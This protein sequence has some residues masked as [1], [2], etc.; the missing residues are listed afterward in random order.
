MCAG[1]A[2]GEQFGG[3]PD[4]GSAAAIVE[5]AENGDCWDGDPATE[6]ICTA[7]GR[8]A[9]LTNV[10]PDPEKDAEEASPTCQVV[11]V[12]DEPTEIAADVENTV[13]E[14]VHTVPLEYG[15]LYEISLDAP[16]RVEVELVDYDLDGVIFVLLSEC[17]NACKNRIAWGSEIC[18]P[19]VEAGKYILAVFSEREQKFSFMV[20]L[21]PPEESC[22]GLDVPIDC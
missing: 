3:D 10:K 11:A 2:T 6:D 17:T 22:N 19:T 15:A 16:A 8:C 5:C 7:D 4:Q 13:V 18:S 20:D 14:A 9:F 21:L 1:C 12:I